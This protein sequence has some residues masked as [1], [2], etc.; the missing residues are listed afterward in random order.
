MLIS[1]I[2]WILCVYLCHE[3]SKKKNL[4]QRFWTLMGVTFGIFT[5]IAICIVPKRQ[6]RKLD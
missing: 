2:L 4:N 3:I 5:L 6:K 1:I